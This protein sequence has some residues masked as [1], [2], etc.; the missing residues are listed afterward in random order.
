MAEAST[1]PGVRPGE[2][3]L[4]PVLLAMVESALTRELDACPFPSNLRAACAH[5]VLAGGKRLRPILTLESALL[6]GGRVEDALPAAVAI[7][8]VHAF[9]L[10]HDDLPALDDDDMRRGRPTCHI[11]F[12]EAMAILAGDALLARAPLVAAQSASNGASIAQVLLESTC[13]MISG[14]VYDTLGGFE[15]GA[16]PSERLELV[17]RNKTGA[18]LVGACRMGALS[19]GASAEDLARLARFGAEIG[20][21]FQVVDDLI[22]ATQTAEHA[23][24]A[25]GKD[26]DA[27]KLTYPVVHGLDGS[28]REVARL[29]AAASATLGHFGPR[30]ARL[31]A[32]VE[33]LANR[34]R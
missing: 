24:K 25:T 18:L 4:D 23:G 21:M 11:A 28:R 32:L 2:A 34:T 10:V 5:A 7:E 16:T 12:G 13:D 3:P 33:F 19:A 15:D 9:S 27:G 17:H 1:I 30:G 26:A 31:A 20:L 6:C 29:A 8:F 14:Q 22:D